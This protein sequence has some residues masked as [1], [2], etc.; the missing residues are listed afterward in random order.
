MPR[1]ILFLVAIIGIVILFFV[2]FQFIILGRSPQTGELKVSSNTAATVLLDNREIGKTPLQ[3]KMAAGDYTLKLV[4]ESNSGTISSWQGKVTVG[5]NVLTY[6]NRDLSESEL[7]SAGEML[8]LEKISSSKAELT[9]I[10]VPEGANVLLDDASKGVTPISLTDL[11]SGD[12]TLLVTSPGFDP[13]TIK[14]KLTAGYKL[15][16]SISLALS[17]TQVTATMDG[18]N[19]PQASV[20]ATPMVTGTPAVISPTVAITPTPNTAMPAKVKILDTPTGYLNVRT[21][22]SVS[23]TKV[24]EVKPG[25]TYS[26]IDMQPGWYKISYTTTDVGWISAQYAQKGE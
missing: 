13:R 21:S 24:G 11:P 15:N 1:K 6:V 2:L 3:Q 25:E 18:T 12:H 5:A 26:V 20:S 8:W 7:T 19:Q 4:P 17:P 14:V 22:P 10:S 16:A 9:A 23:A